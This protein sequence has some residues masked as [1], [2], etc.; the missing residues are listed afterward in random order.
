M[1]SSRAPLYEGGECPR[2]GDPLP[3][4]YPGA[5]SRADNKTEICSPCGTD[6]AFGGLTPV[7]EWPVTRLFG[8]SKYRMNDA[9]YQAKGQ[10]PEAERAKRLPNGILD[11]LHRVPGYCPCP[12]SWCMEKLNHDGDHRG[13]TEEERQRIADEI[14]MGML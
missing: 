5:L 2:C 7:S 12:V 10:N 11:A 4:R 3:Q 9:Y 14:E 13:L 6:E 8:E 1:S